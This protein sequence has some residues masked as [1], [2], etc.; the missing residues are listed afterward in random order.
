[1]NYYKAVNLMRLETIKYACKYA[2]KTD[3]LCIKICKK[4]VKI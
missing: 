4:T 3:K 1:M 2:P